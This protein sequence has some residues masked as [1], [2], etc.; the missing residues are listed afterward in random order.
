M[1]NTVLLSCFRVQPSFK[2]DSYCVVYYYN[3]FVHNNGGWIN[4]ANNLITTIE[5]WC[6]YEWKEKQIYIKITEDKDEEDIQFTMRV[7]DHL[8]KCGIDVLLWEGELNGA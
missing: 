6:F 7:Y 4:T 2:T 8:L 3:N 5:E 1:E